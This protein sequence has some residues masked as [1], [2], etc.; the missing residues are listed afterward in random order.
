MPPCGRRER[1]PRV[2]RLAGR[3]RLPDVPP[4]DRGEGTRHTELD[5]SQRIA[6]RPIP[7]LG[8]AAPEIAEE[9]LEALTWE[10][11]QGRPAGCASL[12]PRARYGGDSDLTAR[13][14]AAEVAKA[15]DRPNGRAIETATRPVTLQSD[16]R[17]IHSATI[18][19]APCSSSRLD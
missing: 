6:K 3:C 13:N 9:K 7:K 16:N 14:A 19:A 1:T 8:L 12:H 15:R 5:R 4:H 18:N 11:E 17:H 2:S 10:L